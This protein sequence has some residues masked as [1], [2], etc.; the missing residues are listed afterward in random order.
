[1]IPAVMSAEE[2]RQGLR[3]AGLTQMAFA[4]LINAA[5]RA[6][7]SWALSETRVPAMVAII[8]RLLATNKIT[9]RQVQQ[10]AMQPLPLDA[11]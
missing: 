8:L 1:M 10:A 7:R 4:R 6:V 5:P 11:K 9:V 2:L 3:D